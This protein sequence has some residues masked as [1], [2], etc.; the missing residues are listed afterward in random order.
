M[1][2]NA[3]ELRVKESDRIAVTINA[4]KACGIKAQELD[5]GFIITGDPQSK[6][7]KPAQIDSHGDHRIAMSFAILGLR[8]GMEISGAEFISTSFPNFKQCLDSLYGDQN[9][10]F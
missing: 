7:L 2:K 4:L 8:C 10:K 9:A 6:N 1:L 3:K 5:D